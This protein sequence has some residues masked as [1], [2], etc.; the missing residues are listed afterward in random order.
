MADWLDS[1]LANLRAFL[2]TAPWREITDHAIWRAISENAATPAGIAL[3]TTIVAALIAGVLLGLMFG[4]RS[5]GAET[6][7][8]K[9]E[10][11]PAPKTVPGAP[12]REALREALAQQG[13]SGADLT[14]RLDAFD[15]TLGAVRESLK[16]LS[17][18]DTETSPL[19]AAAE[20]CLDD[21]D[22]GGAISLLD[23]TRGRLVAMARISAGLAEDQRE[24]AVRAAVLAGDLEMALRHYESAARH[25]GRAAEYAQRDGLD[26]MVTILTKHGTALFRAGN[27]REAAAVMEHAVRAT[28]GA[29]G[30]EHP[31]VARALSRQA[32]IRNA[33]GDSDTAEDLYRRALAIDE[34]ALGGDHPQVAADLNNLAQLLRRSGKLEASEPLFRRV[35]DIRGKAY[36][37]NHR[38]V[39]LATRN[40]AAVL[41]ALNRRRGSNTVLAQAAAARHEAAHN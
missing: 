17:E 36:G 11:L 40:Y 3:M 39:R 32:A 35:L 5:Q 21:G 2:E 10:M 4:R 18:G 6:G 8:P 33:M 27:H 22:L 34:K 19:L 30:V 41:K 26:G 20:R 24:R 12:A 14:T 29:A 37:P 38:M 9:L 28:A 15:R 1:M 7:T 13:I 23:Q 25:F 16:S 31:D